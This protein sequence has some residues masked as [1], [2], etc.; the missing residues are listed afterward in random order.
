MY[1]NGQKRGETNYSQDL[2]ANTQPVRVSKYCNE[3]NKMDFGEVFI[4]KRHMVRRALQSE[5]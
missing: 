3:Y 2:P 5:L 1:I 4:I